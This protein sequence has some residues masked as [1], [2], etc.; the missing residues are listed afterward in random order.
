MAK[1]EAAQADFVW[2]QINDQNHALDFVS[3]SL[4]LELETGTPWRHQ[5][6]LGSRVDTDLSRRR[7]LQEHV[8]LV[9]TVWL[10]GH[11]QDCT[12]QFPVDPGW[13]DSD[14]S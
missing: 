5:A 6:G 11:C 7:A 3:M 9:D 4:S 2:Q 8:C 14:F 10:D 1:P 13:I 12:Q